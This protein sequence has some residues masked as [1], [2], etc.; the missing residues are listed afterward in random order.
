MNILIYAPQ[1]TVRFENVTHIVGAVAAKSV[2]LGNNTEIKW[3]QRV[4]DITVNGLKP[5]FKRQ[6]WSEC[7]VQSAGPAPDSGC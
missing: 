1:S 6:L 4:G 3:H 2:V 7:T 5:L